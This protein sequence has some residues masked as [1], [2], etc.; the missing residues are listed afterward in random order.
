MN[1]D[2]HSPEDLSREA[3]DAYQRGELEDAVQ[4]FQSAKR[5]FHDRGDDINAAEAANNVSVVLLK[6]NRTQE[7]LEAVTGTP[8]IFLQAG[9]QQRE[10][11]ALGN[12]AA[13]LE[14]C[15][16]I[17]QAEEYYFQALARLEENGDDE[18]RTYLLQALSRLQLRDGKP[19]DALTSMQGALDSQP[20]FSLRTRLL[21]KLF[22]FPGRLL[23]RGS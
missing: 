22:E 20:R 3:L 10:V 11:M 23:G 18:T 19:F 5:E 2:S 6:M 7:A 14:A 8:E 1:L 9:D 17:Q 16:E 15:G 12:L 21:R 13:A 4:G